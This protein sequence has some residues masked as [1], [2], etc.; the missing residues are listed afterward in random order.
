MIGQ[1]YLPNSTKATSVSPSRH[2]APRVTSITAVEATAGGMLDDDLMHRSRPFD[3]DL[4]G[5]TPG[6]SVLLYPVGG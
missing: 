2:I 4:L 5:F 6:E 3:H 1:S